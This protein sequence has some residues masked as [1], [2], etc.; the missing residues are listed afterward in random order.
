MN[1]QANYFSVDT[2]SDSSAADTIQVFVGSCREHWLPLKV[3][4]YSIRRNTQSTVNVTP[5]YESNIDIPETSKTPTAFSLQR[6]LPP[7]L[8]RFQGRAIYLDS[9]MVVSADIRELWEHDMKQAKV[10]CCEGWQT[11]VT[12]YDC[13]VGWRVED[14]VARLNSGEWR[15]KQLV[16][17]GFEPAVDHSISGLWNVIDRPWR[18]H[19][20]NPAAKL[21]HFTWLPTQPWLSAR[22]P[23][24]HL[25]INEL[26]RSVADGFITKE[27]I[28]QE[29]ELGHVRP[30]LAGYFGG[31]GPYD[32]K[33]FVR[34]DKNKSSWSRFPGW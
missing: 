9:D 34:P 22:H 3:L 20:L 6:F 12:L 31:T 14:I 5:L 7:E 15:Y 13:S 16:N 26:K 4:E 8:C 21:R 27:D 23:Y 25:W 29:I 19:I 28:L 18:R 11:A 2:A 30:S 32:D 10:C 33:H 24:E 17:Y 1:T